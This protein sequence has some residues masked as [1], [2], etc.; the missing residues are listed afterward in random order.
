M[1][2]DKDKEALGGRVNE[3]AQALVCR[4]IPVAHFLQHSPQDNDICD[5]RMLQKV[6]LHECHKHSMFQSVSIKH[7]ACTV[8]DNAVSMVCGG[9]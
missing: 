7:A 9:T 4:G 3:G 1:I 2:V 5:G 6:H 8:L